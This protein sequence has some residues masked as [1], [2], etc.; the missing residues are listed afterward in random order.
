MK[1]VAII[2]AF[3]VLTSSAFASESSRHNAESWRSWSSVGQ[4]QLTMFFFDIYESQLLTPNGGYVVEKDITPHPLALS[5]TYQRDI[6]Q[7]QLLDA[8]VEQ[9]EKL[10]YEQSDTDYWASRLENIF[11]DIEE[12]NNLTYVTDGYRGSFYYSKPKTNQQLI[13][14]IEEEAF[15]DAFLAIWLSPNTE[16]PRLRERLI[17]RN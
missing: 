2:T 14:S 12:G 9:W 6:S 4:A 15:N 3:L 8:T 7:K 17:G 10:G 1:C 5:I 16:Y 13:G 11:P